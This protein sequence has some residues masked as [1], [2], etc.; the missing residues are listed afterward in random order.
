MGARQGAL[1][2]PLPNQLLD[3]KG[4]R[5][6]P[7][8]SQKLP[9]T[10]E[11]SSSLASLILTWHTTLELSGPFNEPM[12]GA[13]SPSKTIAISCQKPQADFGRGEARAMHPA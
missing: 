3:K 7:K 9:K 12:R 5:K 4:T 11:N 8:N 2:A 10:P 13:A 6:T 1:R